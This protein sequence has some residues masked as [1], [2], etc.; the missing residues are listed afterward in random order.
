MKLL[1]I[2]PEISMAEGFAQFAQEFRLGE[3]DLVF[4][5]G[6]LFDAYM[7][8]LNLGCHYVFQE[9]FGAGEPSDR[10]VN[11]ILREIEG[12]SYRRVIAIGGGTVVDIGK[13][14]CLK[15]P[16]DVLDL[17]DGIVPV[18]KECELIIVPT[19]C[20]T[21]S[22]VTNLTIL[23]ITRR[24]VKQG[25]GNNQM[26]ADHAVLIPE[27]V[28]NLPYPFF[29]YSSID[30]LIHAVESLISPKASPYTDLYAQKAI[31]MILKG[32]MAMLKNGLDYRK[33]IILDFMIASDYAGI[34]FGNAGVGA[35]HAMSYPLGGGYHVPHGESNYEFFT[36][37]FKE[38][39]RRNPEGKIKQINRILSEALGCP[40]GEGLYDTLEETLSALIKRKPLREYG[41][42]PEEC[43]SFADTIIE[44]QQRLLANNYVPFTRDEY[45]EMYRQLY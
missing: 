18:K 43:E 12:L 40:E 35:V 2:K 1:V 17:F 34:S 20:G 33:E 14:L 29:M 39:H 6:F 42:K 25:L 36:A 41:M 24:H 32:Y 23:E 10:M 11:D 37:V 45:V 27:L 13:I 15:L 19:T 4:T 9:K 21:G 16:K 31:E 3:G 5:H 22:E 38:Y 8:P 7:K 28:R 30:A 44:K 26:C